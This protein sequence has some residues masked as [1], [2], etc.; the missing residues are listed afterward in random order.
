MEKEP[1]EPKI[2]VL[3]VDDSASIRMFACDFLEKTMGLST[4]IVDSAEKAIEEIQKGN[5]THVIT[6]GLNGGWENVVQAGQEKGVSVT[7]ISGNPKIE[8][9]IPKDIRFIAKPMRLEQIREIFE[10]RRCS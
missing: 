5:F 4:V 10:E 9:Q 8:E 3:F 2:K 6:D 1:G 7:V